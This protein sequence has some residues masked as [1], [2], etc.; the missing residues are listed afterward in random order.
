M[1]NYTLGHHHQNGAAASAVS[2]ASTVSA[3]SA[4]MAAAAQFY[5]QAAAASAAADPLSSC[6]QPGA[7]SAGQPIPDIPRYP[8]MSITGES[9]LKV[10]FVLR[11]LVRLVLTLQHEFET[12]VYS[13]KSSIHQQCGSLNCGVKGAP[14]RTKN[15]LIC[16]HK[17]KV[18]LYPLYFVKL[19]AMNKGTAPLLIIEVPTEIVKEVRKGIKST[20]VKFGS[21]KECHY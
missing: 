7:T 17:C 10:Q 15:V 5:H 11:K 8:W 19:C 9:H 3:A 14:L 1:V 4:S 13:R 16:L 6:A 18:K 12:L 2:A 20:P 21:G